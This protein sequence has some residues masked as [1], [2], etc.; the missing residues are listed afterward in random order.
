[1]AL[2]TQRCIHQDGVVELSRGLCDVDRLHLL[3]A[4]QRVTLGHEF[5]DG[6]LVE[7]ARDQK[8]DII[9]HVAVPEAD[10]DVLRQSRTI[11]SYLHFVFMVV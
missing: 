4:A 1:M 6:S 2:R 3:K 9:D 11:S 7:G 5:R 8:D 10:E